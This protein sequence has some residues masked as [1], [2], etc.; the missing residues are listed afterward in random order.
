[1]FLI[2]FLKFVI[3]KIFFKIKKTTISAKNINFDFKFAIQKFNK[4]K[5]FILKYFVNN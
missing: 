3:F 5:K 1:L 2:N 4:F